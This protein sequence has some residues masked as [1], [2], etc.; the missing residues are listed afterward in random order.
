MPSAVRTCS[1]AERER[2][3]QDTLRGLSIAGDGLSAGSP[4]SR[5]RGHPGIRISSPSYTGERLWRIHDCQK[6]A[7]EISSPGA[8]PVRGKISAISDGVAPEGEPSGKAR[9]DPS[10]GRDAL[11]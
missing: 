4:I 11:L 1:H 10:P 5:E 2:L 3:R 8:C 9:S 7:E 6:A